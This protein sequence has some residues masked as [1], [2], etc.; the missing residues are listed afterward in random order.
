MFE[1]LNVYA[2]TGHRL[3]SLRRRDTHFSIFPGRHRQLIAGA[4]PSRDPSKRVAPLLWAW[5]V[6][7][8]APVV[9]RVSVSS[10]TDHGSD[11]I[12]IDLRPHSPRS[13]G[14]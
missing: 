14:S 11:G 3:D 1:C 6:P 8:P 9:P 10:L 7:L 2:C 12:V 4:F 5:A 13:V